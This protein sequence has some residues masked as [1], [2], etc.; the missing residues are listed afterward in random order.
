ME[1]KK[2]KIWKIILLIIAAILLIFIGTIA[3]KMI[4][5]SSLNSKISEY[6]NSKNSY[7][8]LTDSN[9]NDIL[10]TVE[11]YKK[12]DVVKQVIEDKRDSAKVKRMIQI[13]YPKQRKLYIDNGTDK[14]ANIYNENPYNSLSSFGVPNVA[15]YYTVSEYIVNG[16]TSKIKEV[17]IDGKECYEVSGLYNTNFVYINGTEDSKIYVEKE[18]GL[19]L[20]IIAVINENVN[21]TEYIKTYEYEFDSVTDEEI[22]EPD[23]TEY[24]VQDNTLTN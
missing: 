1:K 22:A 13:I 12:D 18:T 2:I 10:R 3:R 23:I 15:G 14:I 19:P 21:R 7:A 11:I 5:L 4:I 17:E 16:V 24:I 9:A 20:K 8:K 6:Y